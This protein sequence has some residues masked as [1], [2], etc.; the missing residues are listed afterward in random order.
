MS[1][2]TDRLCLRSLT[3]DDA[4]AIAVLMTPAVSRWLSNFPSPF[5]HDQAED[6][7][8]RILAA[9]AEERACVLAFERRNDSRF[10][11]WFGV[12]RG[13]DAGT[14]VLGYWLGEPF[15]RSGYMAEGARAALPR[16]DGT[17]AA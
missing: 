3:L 1:L 10:M 15:H 2:D 16:G 8:R 12:Y 14:G 9:E 11:G 7:V 4:S 6:R 17:A 5:D 13:S